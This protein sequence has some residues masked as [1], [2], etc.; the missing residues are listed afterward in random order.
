MKKLLV[1]LLL[2][3]GY[4]AVQAGEPVHEASVRLLLAERDSVTLDQLVA[5]DKKKFKG[6]TV[7][8]FL[9]SPEAKGYQQIDHKLNED[10][11][12]Q[13]LKVKYSNKLYLNLYLKDAKTKA[14]KSAYPA[15]NQEQLKQEIIDEIRVVY[16]LY[17]EY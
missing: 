6:K 13:A 16:V 12:L 9:G 17:Q 8:E 3:F 5:I 14:K 11:S 15:L 10:G 7:A 4:T 1:G 2:F